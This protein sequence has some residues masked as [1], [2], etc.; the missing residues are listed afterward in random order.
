M[1]ARS[2][3]LIIDTV[4]FIFGGSSVG[5]YTMCSQR[6]THKCAGAASRAK[7]CIGDA[8]TIYA[9]MSICGQLRGS[10][11][12]FVVWTFLF[13]QTS[14]C[15]NH[16]RLHHGA[17]PYN[18]IF[19]NHVRNR[20]WSQGQRLVD[21]HMRVD[22]GVDAHAHVLTCWGGADPRLGLAVHGDVG[23]WLSRQHRADNL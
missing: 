13:D 18:Q 11:E 15:E 4:V 19:H 5:V 3:F 2:T 17:R 1:V 6:S 12:R 7:S 20:I 14:R 9:A 16:L 22:P 21:A 10:G 8:H 23:L